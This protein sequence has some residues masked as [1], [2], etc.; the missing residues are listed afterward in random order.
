MSDQPTPEEA[1][2]LSLL[3]EDWTGP[4]GELEVVSEAFQAAVEEW[5][6]AA[7]VVLHADSYLVLAKSQDQEPP[8]LESFLFSLADQ[9]DPDPEDMRTAE[10]YYAQVIG[11]AVRSMRA[12]FD[13]SQ[14]ELAKLVGVDQSVISGVERGRGSLRISLLVTLAMRFGVTPS[15]LF[16][17]G[18]RFQR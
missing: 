18:E 8:S 6:D 7:T 13:W 12:G 15:E 1:T 16:D 4:V 17:I 9:I 10:D 3:C 11:A 2:A 5:G 14:A